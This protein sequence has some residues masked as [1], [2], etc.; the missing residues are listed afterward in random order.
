MLLSIT[1]FPVFRTAIFQGDL[2]SHKGHEKEVTFDN[3]EL[4]CFLSALSYSLHEVAVM[5]KG[6]FFRYALLARMQSMNLKG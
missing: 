4:G 1:G 5:G 3:S 6:A 2:Q